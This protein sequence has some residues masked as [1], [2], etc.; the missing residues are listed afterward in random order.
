MNYTPITEENIEKVATN[1][2]AGAGPMK[3]HTSESIK[4]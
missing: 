3:R 1:I 4:W 2:L